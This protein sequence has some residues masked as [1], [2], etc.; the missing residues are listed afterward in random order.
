MLWGALN[1]QVRSLPDFP[2]GTACK[3]PPANGE[4]TGSISGPGRLHMPW[5]NYQ[6][7]HVPQLLSPHPRALE[8]QLRSTP[9]RARALPQET[10]T[11]TMTSSP[12]SP[13]LEKAHSNADLVQPINR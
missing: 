12:H 10:M 2:G 4:D 6:S 5:N 9:A 3:N 8:P 11:M 1:C 13:Q 7:A